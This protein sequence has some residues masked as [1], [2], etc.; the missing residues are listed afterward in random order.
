MSEATLPPVHAALNA[1]MRDVQAVPKSGRNAAQGFKFRGIDAVVN[2]VGPKLRY[3]G[4]LFLPYSVAAQHRDITTSQGKSA[5]ECMVTVV[6]RIVGPAG[7]HLD[8]EAPGE[9]VDISD[10]GTAKAM[11]VAY[12][13]A[14]IQALCLPTDEPDPDAEY[15]ER[16]TQAAPAGDEEASRASELRNEILA[17]ARER[18]MPVREVVAE[19]EARA[20][21]AFSE[22]EPRLLESYLG[23]L[24]SGQDPTQGAVDE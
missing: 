8:I 1:V 9:A 18:K 20:K 13:T 19:F 5:R 2:A 16:A 12:R 23:H 17:H 10:K 6:Y 15:P 21:Q 7:D 24:R 4:V 3:H 11:S 14:L 22:A